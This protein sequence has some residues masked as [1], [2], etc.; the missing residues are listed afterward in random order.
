MVL[1]FL[2][3]SRQGLGSKPHLVLRILKNGYPVNAHQVGSQVAVFVSYRCGIY[4]ILVT[5]RA[6]M[7]PTSF[8]P[9][10]L[11]WAPIGN[12]WQSVSFRGPVYSISW[13]E[14]FYS[15]KLLTLTP[16]E[17]IGWWVRPW[18]RWRIDWGG[19]RGAGRWD[20]QWPSLNRVGGRGTRPFCTTLF[21]FP[22]FLSFFF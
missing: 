15:L 11:I 22:F 3:M 19:W 5:R 12:C 6:Q 9:S 20:G 21:K 14:C 1:V 10:D 8:L 13:A 7:W 17:S 16:G 4:L 2:A 18:W